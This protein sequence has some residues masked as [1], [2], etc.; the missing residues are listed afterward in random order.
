MGGAEKNKRNE[1]TCW[2]KRRRGE[3]QE[4]KIK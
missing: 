3:E 2:E 4:R 1:R